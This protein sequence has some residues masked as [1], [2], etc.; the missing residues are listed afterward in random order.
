MKA[1]SHR[2][3]APRSIAHRSTAHR[4]IARIE[5]LAAPRPLC[6]PGQLA[7]YALGA[8]LWTPALVL[9]AEPL[10]RMLTWIVPGLLAAG[11]ARMF[12]VLWVLRFALYVVG[13]ACRWDYGYGVNGVIVNRQLALAEKVNRIARDWF[14][15]LLAAVWLCFMVAMLIASIV[16]R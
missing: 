7:A 13:A 12:T 8:T 15:V 4:S 10:Q 11:V 1:K 5:A 2:S 14:G 6:A 3:V 9:A 16:G